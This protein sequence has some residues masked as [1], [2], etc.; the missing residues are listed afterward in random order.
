MK[1]TYPLSF[2]SDGNGKMV[3][4]VPPEV[5]KFFN[6]AFYVFVGLENNLRVYS[7]EEWATM[8]ER[9]EHHSQRFPALRFCYA[10]VERCAL[11]DS[12]LSIHQS[13]FERAKVPLRPYLYRRKNEWY[14][15][16][17]PIEGTLL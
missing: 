1:D 9:I 7:E 13:I 14:I 2:T 10:N 16:D 6:G 11:S 12:T 3:T 8:E 15:G 4:S 5:S 17:L